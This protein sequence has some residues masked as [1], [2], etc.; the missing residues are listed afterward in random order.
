MWT[1]T[2]SPR[3][4]FKILAKPTD[5]E[6]KSGFQSVVFNGG[7][8]EWQKGKV[9]TKASIAKV[10]GFEGGQ[11]FYDF[12]I[13]KNMLELIMYDETYPDGGKPEWFGK[14]RTKFVLKKAK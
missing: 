9:V 10:P 7:T 8:Y 13:D 14:W 2:R 5:E 4:R 6:I 3:K 12:R 1:P 11:Q